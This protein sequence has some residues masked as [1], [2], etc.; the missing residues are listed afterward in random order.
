M[1]RYLA[2][3][4]RL[5]ES[6]RDEQLRQLRVLHEGAAA[7]SEARFFIGRDRAVTLW[8]NER[9]DE[10]VRILAAAIEEDRKGEEGLLP[11]GHILEALPTYGSYLEARGEFASAEKLWRA[12]LARPYDATWLRRLFLEL[13]D[14][15]IRALD[16]SAA[17]AP[18]QGAVLY[19]A[20][21]AEIL[22]ALEERTD[23]SHADQLVA[24]LVHL[25]RT[26]DTKKIEGTRED[27]RTFAFQGLPEAIRLYQHRNCQNMVSSVGQCLRDL[28]GPREA[29]AFLIARAE[30]EPRWLLRQ[31]ND[32]WSSQG[33]RIAEWRR[34][35]GDIGDLTPR[36]LAI[37]VREIRR[38]LVHRVA[39]YRN[40]YDRR[41]H[42]FWAE[43]QEDF[44]RAA[45][46][47]LELEPD[48]LGR[49]LYV[50]EY[51]AEGL[52]KLDAAIDALGAYHRRHGLDGP[53]QW[54]LVGYLQRRQRF[55]ESIELLVPM[56]ATWPDKVEYHVALLVAYARTHR[57]G[58]LSAALEAADSHF[59]RA[60]RWT[61]AVI[62]SL[63]WGTKESALFDAAVK[64]YDEAISLHRK[65]TRGQGDGDETLSRYYGEQAEAYAGLGKTREAVDAAAGAVVSWGRNIESRRRAQDSL[66]RVLRESKDLVAFS[67]AFE[68]EVAREGLDK[69]IVRK[70]MAR[71]FLERGNA[72]LAVQHLR[73]AVE[74]GPTDSEAWRLLIE[75]HDKAGN[76]VEAAECLLRFA[77]ANGHDLALYKELGERWQALG[78]AAD[79]ERAYT[80]LAE[81]SASESEGRAM[82]AAVRSAQKRFAEAAVEWRQ[83]VRVRSKEPTGYLGL[84]ES[85]ID[86]GEPLEARRLIEKVLGQGW[87]QHFGDVHDRAR[88]LL[89]RIPNSR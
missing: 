89:E 24:R 41:H 15:S 55:E 77:R 4:G 9:G 30:S 21:R 6:L 46:E 8:A 73:A 53:G 44:F 37:V 43:K 17:T 31:R 56:I 67:V 20:I 38:D 71:V 63:A 26:A 25:T 36:L 45:L 13:Q 79:A 66:L 1:A 65:S 23:E 39:S 12:E 11:P 86:A 48:S 5:V 49:V 74:S 85:L 72:T 22:R 58:D 62:A 84:A 10:A 60:G 57:P 16:A 47:T 40:A 81:M 64:Y 50:A 68:A 78:R 29:L 59:R 42:A 54:Q 2:S 87:P 69:P 83:V 32:A 35:A 19:R 51:V 33:W 88:R 61:E 14:S 75:A 7:G 34:E 70:A 76:R 28:L 27:L 3:V 82:L 52:D 80:T 18:G